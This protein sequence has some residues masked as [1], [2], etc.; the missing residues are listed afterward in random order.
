MDTSFIYQYQSR[1]EASLVS[2][3]FPIPS[4]IVRATLKRGVT[5]MSPFYNKTIS[6]HDIEVNIPREIF[7]E[8]IQAARDRYADKLTDRQLQLDDII[9][10]K[11]VATEMIQSLAANYGMTSKSGGG[12]QSDEKEKIAALARRVRSLKD[13]ITTLDNVLIGLTAAKDDLIKVPLTLIASLDPS[14]KTDIEVDE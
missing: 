10:D 7:T 3:K 13:T 2:K 9:G 5:T 1:D 11:D 8:W 4:V 14:K 6:F 12:L